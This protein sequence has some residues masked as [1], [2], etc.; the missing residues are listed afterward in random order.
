MPK[1]SLRGDLN[2]ATENMAEQ[3]LFGGFE[4]AGGRP[5]KRLVKRFKSW[6]EDFIGLKRHTRKRGAPSSHERP[7]RTEPREMGPFNL[8][9]PEFTEEAPLDDSDDLGGPPLYSTTGNMPYRAR[10][11]RGRRSMLKS[12]SRNIKTSLSRGRMGPSRARMSTYAEVK[13]FET[14]NL[15]K[16][17]DTITLIT[18]VAQGTIVSERIGDQLKMIQIGINYI[19]VPDPSMAPTGIYSWRMTIIQWN[20][21]NVGGADP[22]LGD[23]FKNAAPNQIASPCRQ[24]FNVSR[25]PLFKVMYDVTGV[26]SGTGTDNTTQTTS[27][28]MVKITLNA[29]V[30]TL[31]FAPPGTTTASHH[32]YVIFQCHDELN[33]VPLTVYPQLSFA[34]KLSFTDV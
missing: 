24:F 21:N 11:H 12:H 19:V 32:V 30:K 4:L 26:I 29:P 14:E 10:R 18:G 1:H 17:N 13:R 23:I 2:D 8:S 33:A 20:P 28:G 25:K 16:A 27:T 9:V 7:S 6:G 31:D 5:A 34:A 15:R 22:A 3:A